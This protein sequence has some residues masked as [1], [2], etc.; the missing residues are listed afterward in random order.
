[1]KLT[2]QPSRQICFLLILVV[3]L[4]VTFRFAYLGKKVYWFDEA[5]TSL[6]ISGNSYDDAPI[7]FNNTIRTAGDLIAYQ[8]VDSSNK[9]LLEVLRV[10]AKRPEHAPL[11]YLMAR[12]WAQLFGS[13]PAAMRTLPALISL[14]AIPG[15]FFLCRELFRD[16]PLTSWIATGLIAVSPLQLL[17]AQEAREYS[18]WFVATLFSTGAFTRAIRLRNRSSWLIYAFSFAVGLV[19]HVLFILVG[20][21]HICSLFFIERFKLTPLIKKHLLSIG[22]GIVLVLPWSLFLATNLHRIQDRVGWSRSAIAFPELAKHWI[23]NFGKNFW[24]LNFRGGENFSPLA[25]LNFALMLLLVFSIIALIKYADRKSRL[26]ILSLMGCTT[27][28]FFI[29]DILIGGVR[30]ISPRYFLPAYLTIHLCLVYFL[31]L[32]AVSK[33]ALKRKLSRL[34]LSMLLIGGIASCF[35]ISRADTWWHREFSYYNKEVA[36]IIQSSTAPLVIA[37]DFWLNF[38]EVLSLSHF[39]S[40][41]THLLLLHNPHTDSDNPQDCCPQLTESLARKFEVFFVFKPSQFFRE[42]L[43]SQGYELEEIHPQGNLWR[44][45]KFPSALSYSKDS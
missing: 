9:S 8:D 5:M 7:V 10:L 19:S 4:G 11:Y 45:R 36:Q 30:S 18:L 40:P 28:P 23:L 33:E 41:D 16:L 21:A 3:S 25:Y 29:P 22:V 34:I 27:L 24:D 12:F 32:Y 43:F 38:G 14:L 35:L 17:Y 42:I 37:A 6:R 13:T 20:A 1:M 44:I 2:T 26:I 15:M 31:S 39:L